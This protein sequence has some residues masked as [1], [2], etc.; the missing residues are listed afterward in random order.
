MKALKRIL[1][2]CVTVVTLLAVTSCAVS[3]TIGDNGNW[4]VNGVD[5]G[6]YAGGIKGDKGDSGEDITIHK[7]EKIASV[8]TL[9]S[10]RITFS[11]GSKTI[12][13]ITNG[14]TPEV[15]SF[16]HIATSNDG[17]ATYELRFSDGSVAALRF[18]MG[19]DGADA[20]NTVENLGFIYSNLFAGEP[21]TVEAAVLTADNMM[22]LEENF[23]MNNKHLTASFYLDQL[24]D[25][26]IKVG[27]GMNEYSATYIEIDKNNVTLCNMGSKI[28][29]KVYAHTLEDINSYMRI[30]IDVGS[31]Q[32]AT[33]QI[34]TPGNQIFTLSNLNW[35]GRQGEIFLSATGLTITEAKLTW[36]CD[37]FKNDIYMVGDSYFNVR[38][39]SRWPS[40]LIKSGYTNN[41]MLGFPGMASTDGIAEF[42]RAIEKGT[43]KY[44]FWCMGMNNGDTGGEINKYYKEAV[45]EFL[46]ICEEKG[47]T[48][49]LSTIPSTP[50][51]NNSYKNEYVRM[52]NETRGIRYV[53]FAKAVGGDVY[54]ADLIGKEYNKGTDAAPEIVK[55]TTG[56]DWYDGMLYKDLVHP[57]KTGAQALYAQALIDFPELMQK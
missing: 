41:C 29:E 5:T 36:S 11:D 45:D 43:P 33:L 56:Y 27:H 44:A 34:F 14:I 39:T 1:F 26:V 30:V 10:Y 40:Y 2:L 24:G 6:V 54:N 23:V 35:S 52:L 13:Q 12:F 46:A 17:Q 53:D 49:I 50:I 20:V 4:F 18:T 42:K 21:L 51:I 9:D 25:G 57:D 38:D 19:K 15:T 22:T 8:G 37:D 48:P 55:N 7:V 31:D 47:I 28:D 16:K 32:M 3:P